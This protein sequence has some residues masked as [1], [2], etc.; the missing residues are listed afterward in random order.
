M[1]LSDAQFT[2]WLASASS[3]R[4][5]LV[6]AVARIA[7]SETTL[8]LSNRNYTTGSADTPASTAYTAGTAVTASTIRASNKTVAAKAAITAASACAATAAIYA[9]GT[10]NPSD[11]GT[12]IAACATGT[13]NAPD[14]GCR[15]SRAKPA[16]TAFAAITAVRSVLA[17]ASRATIACAASTTSAA[18]TAS[19]IRTSDGT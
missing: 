13:A 10:G 14:T 6:E 4:T 1:A 9:K 15:T 8:Y 11:T 19:S 7:G 2:A 12:A 16:E 17:C 18:I 3:I 5:V